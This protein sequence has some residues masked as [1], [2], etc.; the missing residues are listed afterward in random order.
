MGGAAFS[1]EVEAAQQDEML[2]TAVEQNVI[3]Q[4]K[5]DLFSEVHAAMEGSMASGLENM[6]GI[7]AGMQEMMLEEL[8]K[9]EPLVRKRQ[10]PLMTFTIDSWMRA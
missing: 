4:I 5:A 2:S 1:A 9:K 7:M 8:V 6:R 3:T 10:C